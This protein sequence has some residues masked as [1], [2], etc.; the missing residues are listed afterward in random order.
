MPASTGD[1]IADKTLDEYEMK[2]QEAAARAL[3][4]DLTKKQLET[5]LFSIAMK[6]LTIL[7]TLGGGNVASPRGKKW[8]TKTEKIHKRSAKKMTA[9]V[10]SGRYSVSGEDAELD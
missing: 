8:L 7:Y 1:E 6:Y 3:L 4:G 10:F 2:L 5:E 9:D